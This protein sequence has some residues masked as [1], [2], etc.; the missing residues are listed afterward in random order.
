MRYDAKVSLCE[1]FGSVKKQCDFIKTRI[2]T[3]QRIMYQFMYVNVTIENDNWVLL[4]FQ[5]ISATI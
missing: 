1:K 4:H 2:K 5:N 3:A